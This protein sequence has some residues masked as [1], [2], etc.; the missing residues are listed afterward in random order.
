M[1]L[2]IITSLITVVNNLQ[3][4]RD[5]KQNQMDNE[6]KKK[7]VAADLVKSLQRAI[8]NARGNKSNFVRDT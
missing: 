8:D 2:Q 4:A 1:A 3:K 6:L 7:T 5:L